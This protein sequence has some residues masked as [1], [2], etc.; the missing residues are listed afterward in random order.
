MP[1]FDAAL[2]QVM[3]Q[4]WM[5]GKRKFLLN[6]AAVTLISDFGIASVIKA[7]ALNHKQGGQLKLGSPSKPVWD[8]LQAG[9]LTKIFEIY[10]V[11]EDAVSSFEP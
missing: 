6:M 7:L 5:A 2:D 4:L 3:N 9:R 10:K 1:V 8:I 11:E